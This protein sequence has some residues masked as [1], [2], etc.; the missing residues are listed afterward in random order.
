MEENQEQAMADARDYLSGNG[1]GGNENTLRLRIETDSLLDKVEE[2]LTGEQTV[3]AKGKE[4]GMVVQKIPLGVPLCNS[5]GRQQIM[6]LC[7]QI[8]NQHQVQGN[9]TKD[10]INQLMNDVKMDLAWEF[11]VNYKEWGVQ[12]R[13]RKHIVRTIEKTIRIFLSRCKDNKERESYAQTVRMHE[14]STLTPDKKGW[15]LFGNN[16]QG[17]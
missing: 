17:E 4:G 10:E 16:T 5:I 8:I 9:L 7:S 12:A 6:Q 15:N 13:N 1:F 3:Y 2:F 11:F 14:T